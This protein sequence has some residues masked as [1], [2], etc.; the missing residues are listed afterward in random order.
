MIIFYDCDNCKNCKKVIK[1]R[2]FCTA[3][4]DGIPFEHLEK[5]VKNLKICSNG[6]GF[7]PINKKA[8]A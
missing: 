7:E 4:P 2:Y 6:I 3:F 8:D 1:D 5:N